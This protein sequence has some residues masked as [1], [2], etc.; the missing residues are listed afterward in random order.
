MS[1]KYFLLISLIEYIY[2]SISPDNKDDIFLGIIRDT[3]QHRFFDDDKLISKTIPTFVVFSY[4]VVSVFS[5]VTSNRG[6]EG[7]ALAMSLPSHFSSHNR[8]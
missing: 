1:L 6:T 8:C 3:L 7:I 5:R 4:L 2:C